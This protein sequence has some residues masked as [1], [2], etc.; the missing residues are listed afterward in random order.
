MLFV[1]FVFSYSLKAQC[2]ERRYDVYTP[3]GNPVATWLTCEDSY[4]ARLGFDVEF[5]NAYP[6]AQKITTYEGLSSTA[7]FNC[8]GYA[9]L[10]VE[11]GI[12]RWIGFATNTEEDIYMSD[13]SYTQVSQETYPGKVS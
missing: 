5:T 8:H 4:S 10:R 9:W 6:N 11:Q 3:V 1:T 2:N 13:G 12:D 7:K